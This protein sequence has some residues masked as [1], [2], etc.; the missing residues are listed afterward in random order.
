MKSPSTD[1]SVLK[2]QIEE[3]KVSSKGKQI[4]WKK[5]ESFSTEADIVTK[6]YKHS[7]YV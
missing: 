6:K 1:K 3:L 2:D 5:S 7:F 4:V